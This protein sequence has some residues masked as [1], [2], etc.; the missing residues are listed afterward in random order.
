MIDVFQAVNH[1]RNYLAFTLFG[2][3]VSIAYTIFLGSLQ[4][5]AS[6]FGATTFQADFIG[7]VV[8]IVLNSYLLGIG[9]TALV[10]YVRYVHRGM[11]VCVRGRIGRRLGVQLALCLWSMGLQQDMR[12]VRRRPISVPERISAL[13]YER[14]Q[15]ELREVRDHVANRPRYQIERV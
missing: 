6:F 15:Y 8:V 2:T 1:G 5:S 11:G 12:Q 14:R 4:V 9:V 13:D 7:V 3:I 10:G